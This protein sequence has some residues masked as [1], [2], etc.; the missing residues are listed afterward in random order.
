[1]HVSVRTLVEFLLRSGDLNRGAGGIADAEAMQA[2]SR[3]HKMLQKRRPS[4]YTA[5]VPLSES[6]PQE[7]G[8][9][10]DLPKEKAGKNL[11]PANRLSDKAA[12]RDGETALRAGESELESEAEVLTADSEKPDHAAAEPQ[13]GKVEEACLPYTLVVEGRADGIDVRENSVTIEEIK[14]IYADPEALSEPEEVHLAQAKC[15]AAMYVK[16]HGL[17]RIAVCMTYCNLEDLRVSTFR[18]TY[19]KSELREWFLSLVSEYAG[20]ASMQVRF[21]HLRDASAEDLKFPFPFRP[22]QREMTS[23]V[24]QTI[25]R[26]KQ[27]F[28]QAPTGIGKTM[29]ALFP[30]LHLMC[31]GEAKRLFY[32]T[33]KTIA[34]TVAEN[35]FDLLREKGLRFRT[36]TITSREKL[37][38]CDTV[39]CTP[40]ACARAKGHYDRVGDAL[41]EMAQSSETFSRSSIL[42]ISEKHRVCPYEL[43]IDLTDFADGIICDYNYAFDPDARMMRFFGETARKGESILLADEAHNLVSRGRE[44]FSAVLDKETILSIRRKL[45]QNEKGLA[46]KLRKAL[47]DCSKAMLELKKRCAES[48]DAIVLYSG[49]SLLLPSAP[50]LIPPLMNV[51]SALQEMFELER[52]GKKPSFAEKFEDEELLTFFFSVRGVLHRYESAGD[53]DCYVCELSDAGAFRVRLLCVNPAEHLQGTLARCRSAVFFSATLFPLTYYEK[54]LTTKEKNYSIY[55]P[56][57][58]PR[59]NRL[60]AVARDVSSRYSRRG[61]SEYE[62]IA[63]YICTAVSEKSGHYMVFFPSYQMMEDVLPIA[64]GQ[65]S[66]TARQEEG[67]EKMPP[68]EA[69]AAE[70]LRVIAQPSGMTED[71]REQFLEELSREDGS[72]TLVAFCVLGGIFSEGIDLTGEKLIGAIVVGTGLPQITGTREALKRTFEKSGQNGFGY[73]YRYPGMNKVLQAAGRVIRT[74]RDRGIIL[75]LD[76]RFLEPESLALLPR[77]WAD[78]TVVTEE[79]VRAALHSFWNPDE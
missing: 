65:W 72:E 44:M 22:G 69:F 51:Y 43:Q 35:A 41:Y 32:L 46:K 34:R 18:Y 14:G 47:S 30:A 13:N 6:F 33:A 61:P 37:C 17:P 71:G 27:I 3:V 78:L 55:I 42:A 48:P 31:K 68:Y 29:S 40:E 24:Y 59:E 64:C 36:L 16:E 76:D 52:R 62:R 21:E 74:E 75:L 38:V 7:A 77:E 9:L 1:M 60:I 2:G 79:T 56:S 58:F 73:A 67:E 20:W 10:S 45:P 15:Y 50:E 39:Q 28:V 26:G 49:R 4:T 63:R 12:P 8:H 54:L 11:T 53:G 25:R 57:P 23:A 19:E 66:A 70:G 5:E